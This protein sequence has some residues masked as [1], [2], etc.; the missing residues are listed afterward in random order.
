MF[1]DSEL[2]S[3]NDRS[4]IMGLAILSVF[5]FHIS[6]F[7]KDYRGIQLNLFE[8]GHI[9]VDIFF[10]LS[11]YG[12]CYSFVK[13][14]LLVFY[15][16]RIKRIFPLYFLFLIIVYLIFRVPSSI[17]N[18]IAFQCTGLSIIYCFNTNVEWYTP[19]LIMTYLLF[20]LIYYLGKITQDRSIW[21][22]VFIINILGLVDY[23]LLPYVNNLYTS[24]FPIIYSGVVLYYLYKNNR[25]KDVLHFI[26]ILV[27]ESLIIDKYIMS[28]YV[29]LMVWLFKYVK[30]R[31][32]FISI[33]YIGKYSFEL[34][35]AQIITTL[36]YMKFS[37]I[38][39]N[40][41]MIIS[42]ILL[43]IPIFFIFVLISNYKSIFRF[44]QV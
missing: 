41:L 34:Y 3:K 11:T 13:N 2:I 6:C 18:S 31:P 21:I 35:L 32:L 27:I 15:Q 12:L 30:Y 38:E 29:I 43:T 33:S 44:S 23:K 42:A 1:N 39:N 24:R 14:S 26:I 40:Y 16:N 9:G 25:N 37:P 8:H 19:A 7:S 36:Y 28:M 4:Y 22:S 17:F 10:L 5:F 20:P